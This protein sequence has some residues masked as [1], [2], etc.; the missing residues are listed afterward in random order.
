MHHPDRWPASESNDEVAKAM[1]LLALAVQAAGRLSGHAVT[2]APDD[3]GPVRFAV[4]EAFVDVRL[5][6]MLLRNVDGLGPAAGEPGTGERLARLHTAAGTESEWLG[7]VERVSAVLQAHRADIHPEDVP[8]FQ[9]RLR[10]RR[11]AVTGA[12]QWLHASDH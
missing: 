4:I 10:D 12:A 3:L 8:A 2:T 9:Q 5:G 7:V 6:R 1:M 11:L